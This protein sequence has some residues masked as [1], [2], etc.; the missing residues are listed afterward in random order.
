MG[1]SSVPI[2]EP[3]FEFCRKLDNSRYKIL[4]SDDKRT[5]AMSIHSYN[6]S[7]SLNITYEMQSGSYRNMNDDEETEIRADMYYVAAVRIDNAFHKVN[8][9]T[10]VDRNNYDTFNFDRISRKN[11]FCVLEEVTASPGIG[12]VCNRGFSFMADQ[13]SGRTF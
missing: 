11:L 7:E 6:S 8:K 12:I 2:Y 1:A 9:P 3:N 4:P 10:P 5:T 13:I